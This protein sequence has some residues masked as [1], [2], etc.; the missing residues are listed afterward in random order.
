M[1]TGCFT[2]EKVGYSITLQHISAVKGTQHEMRYGT[3]T[4]TGEQGDMWEEMGVV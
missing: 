2:R 1:C 4:I 3:M